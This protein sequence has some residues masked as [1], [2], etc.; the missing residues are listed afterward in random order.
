MTQHIVSQSGG[1]FLDKIVDLIIP[2]Y[3]VLFL[4]QTL[5]RNFWIIINYWSFVHFFAGILYYFIHPKGFLM[6][7]IINV[8]FE[9]VEFVLALGGNPLFVEEFIDIIWDILWSLI[10]FGL[11]YLIFRGKKMLR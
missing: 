8:T 1:T 7:L 10:G 4:N 9:I 2:S 3:I 5:Y 6:W 11:M